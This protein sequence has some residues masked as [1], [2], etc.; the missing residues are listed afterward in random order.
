MRAIF[1]QAPQARR[2]WLRAGIG[3]IPQAALD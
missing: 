1:L 3:R 2:F